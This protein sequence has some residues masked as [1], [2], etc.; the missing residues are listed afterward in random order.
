MSKWLGKWMRKSKIDNESLLSAIKNIDSE[1]NV[2]LGSGLYK[3]RVA[4]LNQGKSSGYRTLLVYKQDRL[5]LFVYG[6]AK[7]ERDN[8]S[9]KELSI[10]RKQA[11]QIIELNAKQVKHA[12]A[13]G[14]FIKLESENEK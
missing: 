2:D 6:F 14:D 12:I 11:K 7:N 8:I 5:A 13:C 10:L 3:V 1:N 4:R 9:S